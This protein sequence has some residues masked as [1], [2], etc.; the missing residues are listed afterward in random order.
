MLIAVKRLKLVWGNP[1]IC[2]IPFALP[3]NTSPRTGQIDQK[4]DEDRV[5]RGFSYGAMKGIISLFAFRS[6][7]RR[8]PLCNF[9]MQM[10][11]VRFIRAQSSLASHLWLQEQARA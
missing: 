3:R 2:T 6:V 8:A 5:A 10:R 7:A 9:V 1:A 4:T 11:D